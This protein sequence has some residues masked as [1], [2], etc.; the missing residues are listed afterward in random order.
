MT[1]ILVQEWELETR[2]ST[3]EAT[4]ASLRGALDGVN[5]RCARPV[6]AREL[7]PTLT[8]AGDEGRGQSMQKV[9]LPLHRDARAQSQPALVSSLD[10]GGERC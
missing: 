2:V 7:Q 1:D 8:S 10:E 4:A 9:I 5:V 3:P 6:V